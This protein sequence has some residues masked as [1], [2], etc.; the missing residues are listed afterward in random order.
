MPS[1]IPIIRDIINSFASDQNGYGVLY[2]CTRHFCSH[3]Q[4]VRR[5]W[6]PTW[7]TEDTAYTYGTRLRSY[8]DTEEMSGRKFS[9]REIAAEILQQAIRHSR[10]RLTATFYLQQLTLLVNDSDIGEEY[11]QA[12]LLMTIEQHKTPM[13]DSPKAS[14][15]TPTNFHI[16]KTQVNF[17]FQ[18]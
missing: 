14:S 1:D 6:G 17:K 18:Y 13:A 8:L 12:C 15:S 7:R 10:Y 9:A 11:Q 4:D 3:I 5:S 16:A 2:L